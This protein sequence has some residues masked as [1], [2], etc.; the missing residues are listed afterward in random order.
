MACACSPRT[1]P[2]TRAPLTRPGRRLPAALPQAGR[3]VDLALAF[4]WLAARP[5]AQ[6]ERP[7]FN[8][9]G[10]KYLEVRPPPR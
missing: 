7:A 6:G 5:E 9:P 3:A 8:L 2:N 4:R 1:L 10:N